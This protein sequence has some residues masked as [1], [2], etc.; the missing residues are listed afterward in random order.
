[1][2]VILLET[3]DTLGDKHEIVKVKAGFG[4]NYLIPQKMAIIANKSNLA[5]LNEMKSQEAAREAKL[6]GHYQEIAAKLADSKLKIAAKAGTTGKIFGSVTNV[7]IAQ[8]LKEQL[9]VDVERR[10]IELQEEVKTLGEYTADL[11]LHPE[12][13][14]TV[15]FE[16]VAD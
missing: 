14:A 5:R 11:K 3:V 13:E 10:K 1:M 4:R 8:A 12:V 15:S 2:E 16:V 7:Q 6:L 9:E